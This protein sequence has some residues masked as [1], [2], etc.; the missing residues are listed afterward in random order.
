MKAK[1]YLLRLSKLNFEI[2][3]IESEIDIWR[4]YGEEELLRKAEKQL[5][6]KRQIRNETVCKIRSKLK[7]LS[8]TENDVMTMRFIGIDHDGSG[9]LKTMTLQ[10]IADHYN[11]EYTWVTTTQGRALK[12]L[13]QMIDRG[14]IHE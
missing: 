9:E 5:D 12:K 8:P 1:E 7:K 2:K 3:N 11:K 13:Q 14:E 6:I 10:E 4:S